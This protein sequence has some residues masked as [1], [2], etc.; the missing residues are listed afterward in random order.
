MRFNNFKSKSNTGKIALHTN[1]SRYLLLTFFLYAALSSCALHDKPSSN[2]N[3]S[4]PES[5]PPSPQ[6]KIE[7]IRPASSLNKT[8]LTYEDRKA[9]REVLK[10]PDECEQAFDYPDKSYGGIE[11]F[12]LAEKQYLV[13]VTCT[14]GAYQGY[15]VYY[16]YDE[17]NQQPASKL[18]TFES[19]ESQD[20]KSLTRTQTTELWGQPTFDQKKKELTVLNKFRGIGDCGILATYGFVNGEPVLKQLRAKPACDGKGAENPEK[21]NKVALP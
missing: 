13:Q 11:F 9:W 19:R 20:E 7:P 17:S 15:Q 12:E 14:G 1:A 2:A 10:W 4:A 21:W 5:I 18:L 6:T 16:F 3:Q 8:N